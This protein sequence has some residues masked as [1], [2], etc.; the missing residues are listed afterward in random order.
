MT[1]DEYD[2]LEHG[3]E[4]MLVNEI[5]KVAGLEYVNTVSNN[6]PYSEGTIY[7]VEKNNEEEWANNDKSWISV[8]L[9][10]NGDAGHGWPRERWQLAN[11]EPIDIYEL[12]KMEKGKD[13]E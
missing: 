1:Q 6:G 3:D 7:L 11:E 10:D 13:N 4:I 8:Q 5:K 12:F 9:N 2:A